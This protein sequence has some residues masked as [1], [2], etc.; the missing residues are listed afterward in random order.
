MPDAASELR[1]KSNKKFTQK[2]SIFRRQ[3]FEVERLK[4]K[5]YHNFTYQ[6]QY[7]GSKGSSWHVKCILRLIS[8]STGDPNWKKSKS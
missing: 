8:K 1:N 6:K 7:N 5:I 2:Q 3:N 4:L